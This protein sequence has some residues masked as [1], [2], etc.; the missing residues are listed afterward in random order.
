LRLSRTRGAGVSIKPG[1]KPREPVRKI[2]SPRSGRQP[3]HYNLCRCNRKRYR[4]L[5]GLYKCDCDHAPGGLRPKRSESGSGLRFCDSRYGVSARRLGAH[6]FNAPLGLITKM[7]FAVRGGLRQRKN[8]R[9]KGLTAIWST[10]SIVRGT[11]DPSPQ[12]G[13]FN[14]ALLRKAIQTAEFARKN[15]SARLLGT[16]RVQNRARP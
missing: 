10:F 11:E 3:M 6:L 9:I 16:N 8:C 14:P 15:L 13:S 1:R 5:R 12:S 4:P 7:L 2:T